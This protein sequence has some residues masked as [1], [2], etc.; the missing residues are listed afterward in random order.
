ML[1][2][3]SRIKRNILLFALAIMMILFSYNFL[4]LVFLLTALYLLFTSISNLVRIIRR[5]KKIDKSLIFITITLL[6][7]GLFLSLNY[8][9]A[10]VIV[11]FLIIFYQ[12][13]VGLVCL[14]NFYLLKSDKIEGHYFTLFRGLFLLWITISSLVTV[15]TS[16]VTIFENIQILYTRL[17][18][19]MLILAITYTFD[20]IRINKKGQD[21]SLKRQ[22]RFK[23]PIF[24][25]ALL[26]YLTLKKSKAETLYSQEFLEKKAETNKDK[27]VDLEIWI[28]TSSDLEDAAG[29][30]D[31]SYKGQ[32]F[33]YGHYDVDANKLFGSMGPGVLFV[34]DTEDYSTWIQKYHKNRVSYRYGLSLTEEQ[35]KIVEKNIR[36]L[37]TDTYEFTFHTPSQMASYLGGLVSYTKVKL[38]KFHRTRFKTYFVLTT[39]CALLADFIVGNIGINTLAVA[40]VISPGSY[41]DYLETEYSKLH[42]NIISKKSY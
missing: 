41:K 15:Y 6:F 37:F 19:Y 42:S 29:H 38:H 25:T 23:A 2:I 7:L 3:N 24:V 28:H 4:A 12:F 17:G 9:F 22:F 36:Q 16:D 5:R 30:V 18:W 40:G 35:K 14:F 1:D 27:N 26:P 39:N 10:N 32:T 31:I 34:V 33:S 21:A 13:I 11:Y 8:V 20:I